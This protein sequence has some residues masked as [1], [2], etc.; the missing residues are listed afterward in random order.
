VDVPVTNRFLGQKLL[1]RE[2]L[3]SWN[4]V[5]VDSLIL[6][7]NFGPFSSTALRNRFI[8]FADFLVVW[9]EFKVNY[10]LILKKVFST[11]FICDFDMKAFC[12][13]FMLLKNN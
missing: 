2:C 4:I 7:S 3:V 8:I 6:D 11:D 13:E 9:N 10:L 12:K 1:D 5:M